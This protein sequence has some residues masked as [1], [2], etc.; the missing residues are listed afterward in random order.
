MEIGFEQS[1][2]F[3]EEGSETVS[4][5]VAVLSGQLSSNVIVRL[6]T[7]ERSAQG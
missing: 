1:L 4:L 7:L 2:Y 5:N 3:V 6:L